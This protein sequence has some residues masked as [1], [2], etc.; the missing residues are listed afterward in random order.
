MSTTTLGDQLE[1]L[2]KTGMDDVTAA[3]GVARLV[4]VLGSHKGVFKAL[5]PLLKVREKLSA[6]AK[7]S[8][9]I[10]GSVGQGGSLARSSEA[11]KLPN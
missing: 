3:V 7:K 2:L 9:K 4:Y 1:K 5:A 10:S 11:T 6:R 8:G